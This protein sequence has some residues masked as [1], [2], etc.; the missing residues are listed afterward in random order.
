[1]ETVKEPDKAKG[2]DAL[3]EHERR[4][5]I[6]EARRIDRTPL[7][8]KRQNDNDRKDDFA[9]IFDNKVEA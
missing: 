4:I 5:L 3:P 9:F 1:M 2:L 6:E 8:R 7:F